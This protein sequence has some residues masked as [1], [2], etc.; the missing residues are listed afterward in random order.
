M[1]QQPAERLLVLFDRQ[2][3][4]SLPSSASDAAWSGLVQLAT[5]WQLSVVEG[6]AE[7]AWVAHR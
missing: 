2:I 6:R 3:S 7:A 5:R 1:A 4:C